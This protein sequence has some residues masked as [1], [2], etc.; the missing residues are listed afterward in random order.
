VIRH[1]G[2]E[3]LRYHVRR[4]VELAQQFAGRVQDSELF[5]LAAPAPLNLVCFRHVAGDEATKRLMEAMNES[6]DLYMT[7]TVIGG[8]VA[9]RFSIGSLSTEERHV[10]RAWDRLLATA[11]EL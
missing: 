6:G 2:V 5:E 3:G 9:L 8:R 11:K 10:R 1:Y 4:H 7:H